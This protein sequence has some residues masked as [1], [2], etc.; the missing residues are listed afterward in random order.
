MR[1]LILGVC[2]VLVAPP[3]FAAEQEVSAELIRLHDDLHLS[4]GQEAAWRDYTRSIAPSPQAEARHR[5]AVELMPSVPAPR[6][7][8]LMEATMASDLADFRRQG[9]AVVAFYDQLSPD[10]QR[11]FDGETMPGA[12][13]AGGNGSG[14]GEPLREPPDVRRP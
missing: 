8:A 5:A 2:L 1:W 9:Q 14:Q 11:T 4:E 3:A 7:I 6:R 12:D 13:T 10:Q